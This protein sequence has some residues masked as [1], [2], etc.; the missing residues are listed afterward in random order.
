MSKLNYSKSGIYTAI[1]ILMGITGVAPIYSL[2]P[3]AAQLLP[4]ETNP[5]RISNNI[6]IPSGTRIPLRHSNAEKILV[7]NEE[8]LAV[9]LET[10]ANIKNSY[11]DI[12]VPAGSK[13]VGQIQPAN[14]GAQFVAQEIMINEQAYPLYASSNVVT[15]TETIN[16]GAS[17]EEILGGTLAGSAAA[18]IIAGTTGDRR[19]DA[20]EVLAGAAVGTLAGWGLPEAGIIGGGETEV[21]SIDPNQDLTIT[22]QSNLTLRSNNLSNRQ[23]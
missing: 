3:A 15:S 19:I 11:G 4:P 9:T 10:A 12:L 8:S 7:T 16:E 5:R 23:W 20:L 6:V 14:G 17:V 22:L 18:A 1:A 21:I 13:V 2:K